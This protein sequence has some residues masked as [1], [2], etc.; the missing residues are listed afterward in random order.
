MTMRVTTW[1]E[2]GLVLALR[3]AEA[4]GRTLSAREMADTE[5]LPADFAEQVLLRLRRGGVID[6]GPGE[7]GYVLA[8][9]AEGITVREVVT[10]AEGRTLERDAVP[11]LA[12]GEPWGLVKDRPERPAWRAFWRRLDGFLAEWTLADLAR[13]VSEARESS[14]FPGG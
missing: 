9:Q 1:T 14:Q 10:A 6:A 8:R 4:D 3:L 12:D 7:D 5:G 2:T 13:D 11:G